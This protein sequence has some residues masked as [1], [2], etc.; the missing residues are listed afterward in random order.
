MLDIEL[1]GY[2]SK[3][4]SFEMDGKKIP[5]FEIPATI[6]GR[7]SIRIELDNQQPVGST[8]NHQPVYFT[9]PAP[10]TKL[11]NHTITWQPIAQAAGYTILANGKFVATT[12]LTLL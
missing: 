6:S 7:H 4:A 2:G 9:L 5:V 10:V 8:T 11:E 12:T 1:N 3:I